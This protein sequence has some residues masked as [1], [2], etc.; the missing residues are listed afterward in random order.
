MFLPYVYI[1]RERGSGR[2]YIGMRSANKVLAELDL[3]VVYF[4][5]SKYVKNNFDNFDIEII[6]YFKDQLSAFE[7]ENNLIK[8]YW[9]DPLLINKHYQKSMT[10][11]SMSG[12]KRPDVAEYNKKTKCKP[13]QERRYICMQCSIKFIKTELAHKPINKTP[14]CSRQCSAIHNGTVASKLRKGIK[15]PHLHGR[16]TWNKGISNPQAAINAKN[17]AKKLSE[18]ARGRKRKYL[19]NGSW[20]WEYPATS[21]TEQAGSISES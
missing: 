4:T 21:V 7:F 8:E 13:K 5:S 12:Y 18:K 10:K 11:F 1:V 15:L 19:E 6:A 20:T 14:F 2:F 16:K 3:G 9:G 17:G